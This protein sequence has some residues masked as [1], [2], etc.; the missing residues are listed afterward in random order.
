MVALAALTA[1]D[2]QNGQFVT[3]GPETVTTAPVAQAA[4]P[5]AYIQTFD[6]TP[7]RT[8]TALGDIEIEV[9]KLTA[10]H[11]D[12]TREDALERLRQEASKRGA[13]AVINVTVGAPRVVPLSWASRKVTGTA[14][15]F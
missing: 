14:V 15:K 9:S 10:F 4:T 1:C 5:A 11:P 6:G 2:V 8:F 3:A 13:D 12:P 7:N